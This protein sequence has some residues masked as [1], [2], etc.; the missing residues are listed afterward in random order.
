MYQKILFFT[1]SI[2]LILVNISILVL[3]GLLFLKTDINKLLLSDITDNYKSSMINDFKID[4][5]CKNDNF[6]LSNGYYQGTVNGCMCPFGLRRGSCDDSRDVMCYNVHQ[7][8]RVNFDK[9]RN[10]TLC[11]VR[12]NEIYQASVS[13]SDLWELAVPKGQKCKKGYKECGYLDTTYNIMCI[14]SFSSCPITKVEFNS[15]PFFKNSTISKDK[16]KSIKL[17]DIYFVYTNEPEESSNIPVEFK[18]YEKMKCAYPDEVYKDSKGVYKLDDYS[19]YFYVTR[20][21]RTY[22]QR[23][24][25]NQTLSPKDND[26]DS[27]LIEVESNFTGYRV[28]YRFDLIDEITKIDYFRD[29][30]I[31]TVVSELPKYPVKELE[32][33]NINLFTRT[34]LGIS[35]SCDSNLANPTLFNNFIEINEKVFL[36]VLVTI[37]LSV[38]IFLFTFVTLCQ[39]DS[40]L[41]YSF[42]LA[43]TLGLVFFT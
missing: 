13:Y 37:S 5:K 24:H 17:N 26:L 23:I 22:S 7:T 29:N 4:R 36:K 20:C 42:L 25:Y 28:D 14:D 10:N 18:V 27:K 35:K 43:L 19:D 30:K 32:D 38:G 31:L 9:W 40:I 1:T 15:E 16:I 8:N 39:Y 3:A 11:I 21:S 6:M 34:Y 2:C 41:K 12:E 33:I